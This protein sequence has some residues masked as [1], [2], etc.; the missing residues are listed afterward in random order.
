MSL[1]DTYNNPNPIR[2]TEN[3]LTIYS[4]YRFNN[5]TSDIDK[6]SLS[7][8]FWNGNLVIS[9]APKKESNNDEVVWDNDA[10]VAIYLSHTKARILKAEIENFL[11]DPVTYDGCGANTNQGIITIGNGSEYGRSAPVVTIRKIDEAGNVVSEYAY[12]FKRDFYNSIRDYHGDKE[13]TISYEDYNNIEIEQFVTVLDQY[14]LS[15][16]NA[17]A[18]SVMNQRQF[19]ANR[20]ERKIDEIATALG[21]ENKQSNNGCRRYNSTSYFNNEN[22]SKIQRSSG[23]T[24][25]QATLDDL[26]D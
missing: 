4:G 12:E 10:A 13:Y 18:F 11:K 2:K 5:P 1:G 3:T 23:V 6:T 22:A 8:R 17:V 9:I 26:D 14:I 21:V 24:Y 16:T 7:F 25:S 19:S 20:V 15:S